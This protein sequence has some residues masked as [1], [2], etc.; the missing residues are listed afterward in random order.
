MTFTALTSG[1][2][3][4]FVHTVVMSTFALWLACHLRAYCGYVHLRS[5]AL[6]A[7]FVHT[8]VMTTFVPVAL[9]TTFVSQGIRTCAPHTAS[10]LAIS[11]QFEFVPLLLTAMYISCHLVSLSMYAGSEGVV[12]S[13]S[14]LCSSCLREFSSEV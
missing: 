6:H 3:A 8:V 11:S 5:V 2:H 10:Y 13:M 7:T 1:L 12:S 4:T 14:K 9:Y